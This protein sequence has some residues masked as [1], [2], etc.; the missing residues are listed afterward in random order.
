M[1][2]ANILLPDIKE[3]SLT[4]TVNI[5]NDID[6]DMIVDSDQLSN[7]SDAN[8]HGTINTTAQL[9]NPLNSTLL[10]SSTS[11]TPAATIIQ[12]DTN[13]TTD[14]IIS[15]ST[16]I[17]LSS[18]PS[19]S[20]KVPVL[21]DDLE[22]LPPLPNK[23]DLNVNMDHST[24]HSHPNHLNSNVLDST[25]ISPIPIAQRSLVISPQ[26]LL[27]Q[28]EPAMKNDPI[29]NVDIVESIKNEELNLSSALNMDLNDTTRLSH[30]SSLKS[31]L[32]N[33][34]LTS[35][36]T[37]IQNDDPQ[38]QPYRPIIN[39]IT[40]IHL[41]NTH[42]QIPK[43]VSR[44][45]S[46]RR[47]R[48]SSLSST[49]TT[50]ATSSPLSPIPTSNASSVIATK[51]NSPKFPLLRKASSTLLRRVSTK[52]SNNNT[53]TINIDSNNSSNVLSSNKP[54]GHNT[55]TNPLFQSNTF[56]HDSSNT[57]NNI[58]L[59]VS[60]TPSLSSSSSSLQSNND[61]A[62]SNPSIQK[63]RPSL[64][65]RISST[66]LS[67][68]TSHSNTLQSQQ[69]PLQRNGSI[70]SRKSSLGSKMK[71]N[72]TRIISDSNNNSN[73]TTAHHKIS[74]KNHSSDITLPTHHK[75][76]KII[77]GNTIITSRRSSSTDPSP[78]T[79]SSFPSSYKKSSNNLSNTVSVDLQTF[80]S[81]QPI[82]ITLDD[83]L[84]DIT[85]ISKESNVS[86]DILSKNGKD[87]ISLKDYYSLLKDMSQREE[88]HLKFVE[89]K[90]NQ[91][92]W[93]SNNELNQLKKKRVIINRLWKER[94][95][96][97]VI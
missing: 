93:F 25:S 14:V 7:P 15:D 87:Q 16:A 26:Q 96:E 97:S 53:S 74:S 89:E 36:D 31:V 32:K 23:D 69:S 46:Y 88:S 59:P 11:V 37:F 17:L 40:P 49:S 12:N 84:P 51:T 41:T 24:Q 66:T 20:S 55:A 68:T 57:K 58:I 8:N 29:S 34:T 18:S 1:D 10:T 39:S 42:I 50:S 9:T 62:T 13:T 95:Q 72:I 60:S 44:S 91:S 45:N 65:S 70:L 76:T 92:G 52:T 80:D 28:T 47:I 78:S 73:N 82:I 67:L 64:R 79:I 21:N 30:S 81:N 5:P 27:Q 85:T 48:D 83:N 54:T 75:Q 63:N 3:E 6:Y 19:L 77:N 2:N 43:S 71:L 90:F 22:L 94:L 35:Q 38:Q 4:N 33:S 61:K 56:E 86:K